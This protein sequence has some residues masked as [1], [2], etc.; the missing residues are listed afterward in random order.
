MKFLVDRM[1]GRLAVWLRLLGFDAEYIDKAQKPPEIIYRSL[2][3]G[4][5]ILTR[6]SRLSAGRA[7]ALYRVKSQSYIEQATEVVRNFDLD[8]DRKKLFSRCLRCNG[9]IVKTEKENVRGKVPDFVYQ[10]CGEFFLCPKCNKIY[11]K[12]SHMALADELIKK[13]KGEGK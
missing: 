3:D 2:R 8:V 10:T 7:Y 11:W 6:N 5:V 4:R 9:N 1:C 13:I 12:G